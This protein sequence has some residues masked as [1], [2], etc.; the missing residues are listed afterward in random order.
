MIQPSFKPT[1]KVIE[2][3][4]MVALLGVTLFPSIGVLAYIASRALHLEF[5]S[6][7]SII[8]ACLYAGLLI[9]VVVSFLSYYAAILSTR[10]GL[11]PDSVVIPMITGSMDLLGTNSLI[12][13]L[14]FLGIA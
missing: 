6:L 12:L 4:S 14:L 5:A 10:F 7:A 9:A 1:R 11:D 13:A 2:D 8:L 3:F